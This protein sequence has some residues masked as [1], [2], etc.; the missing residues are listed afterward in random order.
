VRV[1]K[2]ISIAIILCFIGAWFTG[3]I[4]INGATFNIVDASVT[5]YWDYEEE[6]REAFPIVPN[7]SRQCYED[8]FVG[9]APDFNTMLN[10]YISGEKVVGFS[11][12][13]NDGQVIRS[14]GSDFDICLY[15]QY[16]NIEKSRI[17]LFKHLYK[18]SD[19]NTFD[20]AYHR[21]NHA[22]NTYH[23]GHSYDLN[24]E[25]EVNGLC[26]DRYMDY[27]LKEI[28]LYYTL[29][30]IRE[31]VGADKEFLKQGFLD[32]LDNLMFVKDNFPIT[33]EEF[34]KLNPE[35]VEDINWLQ[36][37][38]SVELYSKDEDLLNVVIATSK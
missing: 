27:K 20:I 9:I 33:K 14:K 18:I 24:I 2:Y 17:K 3:V 25:V 16:L 28:Y 26:S 30:A 5:T 15:P 29:D 19:K 23:Q 12:I 6:D 36:S 7:R 35:S 37:R 21:H 11:G 34:L 38:K 8:G 1:L 13:F 4:E 32:T 10:E 22:K 31:H